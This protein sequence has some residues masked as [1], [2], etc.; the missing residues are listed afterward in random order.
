MTDI[1][2]ILDGYT[3]EPSCLGVPPFLAP[4]PRYV[5]GAIRQAN[6][7]TDINYLT[8]DEYRRN[9]LEPNIII[10]DKCKRLANSKLLIIIAGAIVPGKYLRGT[11]ISFK[12][13]L[14]IAQEFDSTCFFGGACARFGFGS[15][16]KTNDLEKLKDVFEFFCTRDLDAGVYD[17]L[18]TGNPE[19]RFRIVSE[20]KDW[21]KLG[22]PLVRQYPDFISSV[23]IELE[24]ARG[25]VRYFTGGCSF[26]SEPQFGEPIFRPPQDVVEEVVCLSKFDIVNFRLG[27]LSCIFSYHAK[28]IGEIE[29]PKP[30]PKS[31]KQLLSGI[32]NN[33]PG[34]RVLHLDNANPAV[35]AAHRKE[36]IEILK[37]IVEHCTG[38]NV[39]SF[40][41]ESADPEV[42]K[43]NNL[44]TD[45][46]EVR[47]MI[48]LVNKYGAMRSS[49]GLSALLPGLNFV[50]GLNKQSKNTFRLNFEFLKSILDQGL[51]LRRI[52]LR[53]V[54]PISNSTEHEF[55]IKKHHKEFI[56]HKNQ[57]REQIDQ[58]MLKRLLPP[59]TLMKN[60][61]TEKLDGKTTFGRQVG[62]Y[63]ILVGIPYEL[64]KYQFYNV[65]ITDY[66]FRSITGFVSPFH[67][68][69]ASLTELEALPG[70]GAKRAAR[71]I[72]ARPF[73]NSEQVLKAL[74]DSSMFDN[75]K[76]HLEF[77]IPK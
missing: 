12:E 32:R 64:P 20:C 25:C 8:I 21:A 51:L 59:G 74:D 1:I 11:P 36:T 54:F 28:G 60:V 72:K 40:G 77:S 14:A 55:N 19:N 13:T 22:A 35:M 47:E 41:L 53:Q 31:V 27:A 18:K 57:V 67:I 30:N 73:H 62:T 3:D 44:N 45:P 6:L 42:I 29:T 15:R 17:Y 2:T 52:N 65:V 56:K 4:L 37:T 58:P 33:S 48:E 70:I 24:A 23:I 49:T 71:L 9:K 16:K 43:A 50:F 61:Y 63:P 38:G 34:L 46:K 75:F 39:L 5:Y 10:R 68:N 7:S 76:E 26:C 69:S 66:G